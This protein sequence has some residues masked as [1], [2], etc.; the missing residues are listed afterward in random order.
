MGLEDDDLT[1]EE[2]K[3]ERTQLASIYFNLYLCHLGKGEKDEALGFNDKCL[4]IN[5]DILGPTDLNVG[6][7]Y[8]NAASIHYDRF[9]IKT[10]KEYSDKA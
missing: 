2:L 3:E 4:A 7:N 8:H 1:E 5:I 6:N 9:E 10:A